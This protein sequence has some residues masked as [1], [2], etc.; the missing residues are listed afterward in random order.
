MKILNIYVRLLYF[1][2]FILN[3]S[4]TCS[5]LAHSFG[6]DR[7]RGCHWSLIFC[8]VCFKKN[9][10]GVSTKAFWLWVSAF[11]RPADSETNAVS[12]WVFPTNP[13]TKVW[14][15][16]QVRYQTLT[17]QRHFVSYV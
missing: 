1:G 11:L 3:L 9:R 17:R 2:G 14:A 7:N 4:P 16:K 6:V 13:N 10:C 5:L 15:G 12:A 8:F